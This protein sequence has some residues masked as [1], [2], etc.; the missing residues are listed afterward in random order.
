M[1]E[2]KGTVMQHL[3][4]ILLSILLLSSPVI[5]Q[6]I[7][8]SKDKIKKMIDLGWSDN[9]IKEVCGK[10]TKPKEEPVTEIPSKPEKEK[11]TKKRQKPKKNINSKK[12]SQSEKVITVKESSNPKIDSSRRPLNYSNKLGVRSNVGSLTTTHL[13]PPKNSNTRFIF[14]TVK[15]IILK[16]IGNFHPY[17]L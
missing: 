16:K 12:Y 1:V 6:S 3:L 4:I 17:T 2:W 10:Y 5:G 11:I 8:C 7:N 9:D 15:F 13:N 14:Y